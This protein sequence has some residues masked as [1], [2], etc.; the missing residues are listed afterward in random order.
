MNSHHVAC[1]ACRSRTTNDSVLNGVSAIDRRF[2][3][4]GQLDEIFSFHPIPWVRVSNY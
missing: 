2:I 3:M 4:Y 1:F